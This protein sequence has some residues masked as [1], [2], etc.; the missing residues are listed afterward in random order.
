MLQ[1]DPFYYQ[2]VR[3][4]VAAF[5]AVFNDISIQR[6]DETG[7]VIQTIEVPITYTPKSRFVYMTEASK[8][9]TNEARV[10]ITLPRMGYE[11][12]SFYYD[13]SRKLQMQTTVPGRLL[14]S[15]G[16]QAEYAPVPYC[17]AFSMYLAAKNTQDALQVIE[18][19]IPFFQPTF[20]V[21]IW[22]MDSA[23]QSRDVPITFEN[24]DFEDS[25]DGQTNSERTIIWTM[26]FT[27]NIW[28][29]GPSRE[30]L[31]IKQINVSTAVNGTSSGF[32]TQVA[33]V[34]VPNTA[35]QYTITV[36]NTSMT[37]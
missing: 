13:G 19:I 5:G 32:T 28:V 6:K 22:E 26:S 10:N 34:P 8:L 2:A 4:V 27:A 30:A 21:T 3:K 16:R 14:Q 24:V 33:A 37:P 36:T 7:A 11:M 17:L 31:E 23:Q 9:D 25:W 29:H 15:G 12:T 18:Q 1:N 20:N 35:D